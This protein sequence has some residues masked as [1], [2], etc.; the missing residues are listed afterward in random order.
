MDKQN[1]TE[2]SVWKKLISFFIPVMLGMLFQQLYNTIDAIIVGTYVGKDALA[3]VG[4]S[5]AVIIN[6]VIGFFTGLGT[7]ATV[8]SAQYFGAKDN[9]RLAATVHTSIA[10][11]LIV[12]AVLTVLGYFLAP[13]ALIMIDTP[14]DIL[15]ISTKY[16]QIYF[17]GTIFTMIFN[18][19]SGL[20]R[21]VGDSKR[22]LIYLFVCCFVNT[23]L[24][25]LFVCYL[26]MGTAG[27]G[28]AT[29][30]ALA[31]SAVL[32]MIS[33][34]VTNK[35]YK[36]HLKKLGIDMATL[37]NTL[38]IG[39][40]TGLQSAMYAISNLII[41]AAI[42]RLGTSV[43]ASWTACGKIEGVYWVISNAIGVTICAFVGQCFGAGKYERMREGVKKCMIIAQGISVLMIALLLPFGRYG[44][45]LINDDPEVISTA[46]DMM[47]FFVPFYI[48][49]TVIEVLSGTLRGVG[50]S[51]RP[52]LIIT[53][54]V[55]LTRVIWIYAFVPMWE[56]YRSI[57]A[58]YPLSWCITAGVLLIY[59][60][61]SNWLARCSAQNAGF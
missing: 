8:I 12:G 48:V 31:I 5:P 25:V 59:Y 9:V 21:A 58:G 51:I 10:F 35:P 53:I 37:R 26:D 61:R 7:G 50:D 30:I 27:A 46:V 18:I 29:V 33:L 4:G 38:I 45:R 57:C 60:F 39:V 41:Q 36:L 54:G 56:G 44:L 24:D 20:L 16:L 55:C 14:A 40:P 22:P 11:S 3:A 42:N 43:V 13:W 52:T 34:C 6:L 47:F 23:A 2:G 17:S 28:W 32:V 1:L 19:G 15:D 49:W